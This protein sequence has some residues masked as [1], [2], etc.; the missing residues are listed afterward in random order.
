MLETT[1]FKEMKEYIE[2]QGLNEDIIEEVVNTC[3]RLGIY[4]MNWDLLDDSS[5]IVIYNN[6]N[7]D[8]FNL[9]S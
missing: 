8:V 5:F 2:D 1:E 7:Y 9:Y 6:Y 4:V 3:E